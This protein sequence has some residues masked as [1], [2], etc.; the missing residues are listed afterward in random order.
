MDKYNIEIE[1]KSETILGS[2]ESVP[3]SV[4]LEVLYDD[5]GLPYLKGKTLKGRLREE[6]ENITR[7]DNKTFNKKD[8]DELFGYEDKNEFNKIIFFD[9]TVSENVKNAINEAINN[10]SIEKEDIFNALTD[11]R[12]FTSIGKDGVALDTTLRQI[13]VIHKGLILNAKINIVSDLSEKEEVLLALSVA[14]LKHIGLMCNRGKGNVVCV[15]YKN[16]KEILNDSIEK[17]KGEK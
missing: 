6:A 15:L 7:L 11:T 2:G 4:D 10:S 1:L 14:S 16:G 5:Y 13:R 17:Y 3:G 8:I 12:I 9:A